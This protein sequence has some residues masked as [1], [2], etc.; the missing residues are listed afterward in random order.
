[1]TEKNT[2]PNL[3]AKA[4]RE[5]KIDI[6]PLLKGEDIT[7]WSGKEQLIQ[8]Y[9]IWGVGPEALY[10]ITRAEHK[11]E[12]D[13]IKIKDFIWLFTEYYLS[14]RNTHH[15]RE[16]CFWAK[17]TAEE[18]PLKLWRRLIEIEKEC[19]FNTI[20]AEELLIP[21][22]KTAITDKKKYGTN[23]ERKNTGTEKKT[24]ELVKQ[25]TTHTKR[26]TRKTQYRRQKK[27]TQ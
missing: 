11:R 7:E 24:F 21:K 18:T 25:N 3:E 16:D 2:V 26:R 20:S 13:S 1:M 14:K 9:L 23:D 19:N 17:Q 27:N 12:P 5:H 22:Y 8:E 4:K 10:Q 15:N 6:A